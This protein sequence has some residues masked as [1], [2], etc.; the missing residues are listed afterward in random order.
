LLLELL[1]GLPLLLLLELLELLW[2]QILR[3]CFEDLS[4]E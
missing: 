1:L 2:K 4:R 3:L